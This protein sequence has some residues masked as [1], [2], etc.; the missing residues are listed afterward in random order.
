MRVKELEFGF[1]TKLFS[2]RVGVELSV[3]D[4]VTEDQILQVL[5]S[6]TSG[7]TSKL[8]NVGKSKNSGVEMLINLVPVQNSD[9]RW[10]VSFNAAYN[11]SEV[12]DLGGTDD[13]PVTE[14]VLSQGEVRGQL[15][16]VLGA[17]LGQLRG[18]GYLKDANGNVIHDS[19]NGNYLT[20]PGYV[21]LGQAIPK[22]VGGIFNSVTYKGVTLSV[23]VDFKLGHELFST[24]NFN[25]W[26]HGLHKGTLP[27][28][29][30]GLVIGEGVNQEGA[31]NTIGVGVDSY[32]GRIRG[33]N[34]MEPFAY[35]AGFW[36][37]RQMALGYDF[38]KHLQSVKFIKGLRLDFV[39][40]NLLILKKWTPNI[41]PEQASFSSDNLS[42]I[43]DPALPPTRTLGFNLNVK[44]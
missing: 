15:W 3:Y 28:R 4:K 19:N 39:A 23:L 35:N 30:T 33:T 8:Q 11:K 9:F 18:I 20:T 36:K 37:I 2:N 1:E 7:Y 6:N 43:E 10:D 26:R 21:A 5:T 42:G 44:F 14:I 32:Y 38:T 41:D 22:W 31:T 34:L 12:L 25:A 16:H 40:N 29:D 27:G 13:D 17:P 24:T